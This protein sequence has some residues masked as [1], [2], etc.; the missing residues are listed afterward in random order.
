MAF[1][2]KSQTDSHYKRIKRFFADF[3]FDYDQIALW[4]MCCFSLEKTASYL[5][6]DRTNWKWG[7][8]NIN[9]LMLSVVYK[10]IALPIFWKALNKRGNS[11][12]EERIELI[13]RFIRVFGKGAIQGI[14]GDR[15]FIGEEWISWLL[16]NEISFCLRLRENLLVQN[17]QGKKV[18]VKKLFQELNNSQIR[19]LRQRKTVMEQQVFLS[20]VKLD[21]GEYLILA[22]DKY[23]KDPLGIYK[24]RWEI[25]TLFA[26][27][28]SKGFC[29]EATHVTKLD[30]IE[31]ILVLAAL[32]FC[33]A[34]KT[35][36]FKNEQRPIKIQ[37]HGRKSSSLFRYGLDFL[38]EILLNTLKATHKNI[39]LL[40]RLIDIGGLPY[41]SS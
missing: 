28:K 9:I 39:K 32:S 29:F 17:T 25:E 27:F 21:T 41:A 22:S 4:V 19:C 31:K 6:I 23:L 13:Q 36:E 7:Q 16:K 37:K 24:K 30:R 40:I 18:T 10:G 12:T 26:C 38:R 3:E 1:G 20:G 2:G 33:W 35:G 11:S 15:E 14:L 34:H 5:S 8:S